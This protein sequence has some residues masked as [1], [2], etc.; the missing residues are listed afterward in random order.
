[1]V[2]EQYKIGIFPVLIRPIMPTC[3][4]R[5]RTIGLI[6]LITSLVVAGFF[7]FSLFFVFPA[8]A[9]A[10]ASLYVQPVGGTFTLGGTFDVSVYVN[11]G[12]QAVNAVEANLKF[13]PDKLQV[14]SP[15]TGK[16]LVQ[17]WVAQPTYS[18]EEGTIKFQGTVPTPGINTDAGLISTVTF[19]VRNVGTATVRILDSSSVLLNDG[20]GTDILGQTTDGIYNLVLP[21]P[22]GPVVTSRTHPDQGKWYPENSAVIEW[23][24]PADA[25]GYSYILSEDIAA[26]PDNISEG[27]RTRVNYSDL[28]DGVYYFHIKA[29][30]HGVWGGITTYIFNIDKTPPA[31]FDIKFSPSAKTSNKRPI[32]DFITTDRTSG[33]DHYE[34]KVIPLDPPLAYTEQGQP[35]FFEATSPYS[36]EFAD[37]RYEVI[38]RAYDAAGNY[39]QAQ[40]RLTV[41]RPLFEFIIS[42]GL[43]IGGG[44]VV[45]WPWLI[46]LALILLAVTAYLGWIA[47]HWHRVIE[48]QLT[49]GPLK[50]PEVAVKL[51]EL[52]EKQKEY[53]SP[54]SSSG[55]AGGGKSLMVL[56]IAIA[57]LLLFG[58]FGQNVLAQEKTSDGLSIEPPVVTLF[59]GSASNDE[60]VYIGGRASAPQAKVLIYLQNLDTGSTINYI[61]TT[62][63]EGAWFY[64]LPGFLDAGNY[65]AWTQLQVGESIS[66]PSSRID[67]KVARTAVQFGNARLSFEDLY[68]ILFL[69]FALMFVALLSWATYHSYHG[70]RKHGKLDKAIK[71]A[72]ESIRRGFAVIRKDIEEELSVIHKAKLSKELSAEER[73]REEKL[74]NDLED[75]SRHVGRELWELEHSDE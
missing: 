64:S 24:A 13:S 74:L 4:E 51:Q 40:S 10:S 11:T 30:R 23:A 73:L 26:E 14:V 32:I 39:Y 33:I 47:W 61:A 53:G 31:A 43:R 29:L 9:N 54:R 72:E 15:T 46:I 38:V 37:G 20:K 55:E 22:A 50:H 68:F 63:K 75:V 65:I 49:H 67:L 17:V 8:Q 25:Q 52:K 60:I 56:S 12:G 48:E 71:E 1:M 19:R 3:G 28:S 21:P 6:R 7:I 41:T 18:N 45:A 34:L 35:F 62:D 16:S 42:D 44:Y 58:S 5:S 70:R 57:F 36:K 59:P 69:V 2:A 66:P 27:F